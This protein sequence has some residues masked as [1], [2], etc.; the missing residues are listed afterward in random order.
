MRGPHAITGIVVTCNEARRLRASLESLRFCDQLIVTDLGSTDESVEI[1]RQCGAE[2][3][4]RDR[5]PIVEHIRE[6]LTAHAAHDWIIFLDPDEVFPVEAESELRELI[7]RLPTLAVITIGLQ[8]YFLGRPLRSTLWGTIHEKSVVCHRRRTSFP[9][10]VH[11]SPCPLPGYETRT[12]PSSS[13]HRIQH[14]WVDS[15]RQLFE[16]HWRYIREEGQA[17]YQRGERFSWR[18]CAS[19]ALLSLKMNLF[20][21]HAWR[22]GWPGLFL[23]G[24]HAWYVG[25]GILSL[26]RCENALDAD[27]RRAG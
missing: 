19:S 6:E 11:H 17:R 7:E 3:L 14:Y 18:R 15:Y 16:K 9:K 13:R 4:Q 25:M 27:G 20:A 22:G 26:R 8:F 10:L 21:H 1:A 24:F 5:V 2:I 23:S 12:L